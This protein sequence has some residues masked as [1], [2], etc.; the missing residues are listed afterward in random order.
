MARLTYVLSSTVLARHDDGSRSVS[1]SVI[2]GAAASGFLSRGW[3][4]RSTTT[5][6]DG[7]VSFGLTMG[8]RAGMN[9]AREYLPAR[10]SKFLQ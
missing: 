6:G 9:V 4:P 5:A 7:A 3:Q 8:F 1:I 2:S 10:F